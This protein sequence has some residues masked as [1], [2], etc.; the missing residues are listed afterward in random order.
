MKNKIFNWLIIGTLVVV[1]HQVSANIAGWTTIGNSGVSSATD[2]VVTIPSLSEIVNVVV[3]STVKTYATFL[4][5]LSISWT[6]PS[7]ALSGLR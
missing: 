2:G 1:S 5:W 7:L 3:A 4:A 6:S